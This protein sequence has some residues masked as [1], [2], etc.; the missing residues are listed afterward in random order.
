VLIR[1]NKSG[2]ESFIESYRVILEREILKGQVENGGKVEEPV[3]LSWKNLHAYLDNCLI[4]TMSC[5]KFINHTTPSEFACIYSNK[6][7]T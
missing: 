3:D 5:C 2:S 6:L 4:D 1:E 7:E